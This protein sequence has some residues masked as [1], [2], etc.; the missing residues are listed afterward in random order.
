MEM[1]LE[2]SSNMSRVCVIYL[3]NLRGHLWAG[4]I[5]GVL[6]LVCYWF[7]LIGKVIEGNREVGE[8]NPRL[9]S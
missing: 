6:T 2:K 3:I 5:S 9:P 4:R 1:T 8:E 7:G